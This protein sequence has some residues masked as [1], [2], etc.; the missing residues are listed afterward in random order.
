MQKLRHWRR[1]HLFSIV[2]DNEMHRAKY[3]FILWLVHRKAKCQKDKQL[4]N[5]SLLSSY[6]GHFDVISRDHNACL[7]WVTLAVNFKYSLFIAIWSFSKQQMMAPVHALSV[8]ALSLTNIREICPNV[9]I[10]L[11]MYENITLNRFVASFEFIIFHIRYKY[12]LWNAILTILTIKS[13][14]HIP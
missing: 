5:G 6:Q 8:S 14:L 4:D 2:V 12:P 7:R 9:K 3:D 11:R 13:I 1:I 10:A